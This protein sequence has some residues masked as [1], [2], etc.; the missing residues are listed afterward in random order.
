[1]LF[2]EVVMRHWLN[3]KAIYLLVTALMLATLTLGVAP[4]QP[5]LATSSP[6]PPLPPGCYYIGISNIIAT[7]NVSQPYYCPP[8]VA[9]PPEASITLTVVNPPAGA[10]TA[11]QWSVPGGTTWYTVTSWVGPLDQAQYGW[12]PHWIDRKDYGTGP[13]RWVV[14]DKD[15]GQGGK[16]LGTSDPFFF[17]TYDGQMV[18][19]PITLPAPVTK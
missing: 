9:P 12:M 11:V 7:N 19:S 3:R 18:W 14:Y 13:F 4:I 10:W 15:P 1:L 6:L 8:Q 2:K 5:A 16:V 17:P